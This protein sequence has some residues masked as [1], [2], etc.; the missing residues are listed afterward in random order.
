MRNLHQIVNSE[1]WDSVESGFDIE[2][3]NI[4]DEIHD[5]ID[6]IEIEEEIENLELELVLDWQAIKDRNN[7]RYGHA[8]FNR[9]YKPG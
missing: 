8:G 4:Q 3:V 5:I 2:L 9:Q 1:N 6:F 7:I